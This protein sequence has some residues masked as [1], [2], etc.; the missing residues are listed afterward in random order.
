MLG[1]I[2]RE[3]TQRGSRKKYVAYDFGNVAEALGLVLVSG[4]P[5]TNL[6]LDMAGRYQDVASGSRSARMKSQRLDLEATGTSGGRAV[7]LVWKDDASSKRGLLG[8][9]IT[10]RQDARLS[11]SGVSGWPP[12]EV[13]LRKPPMA[14]IVVQPVLEGAEQELSNPDLASRFRLTSSSPL[15]AGAEEPLAVLASHWL[16]LVWDGERLD[17]LLN[18]YFPFDA[19]AARQR[20]GAMLELVALIEAGR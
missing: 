17:D 10:Y 14:G 3:A 7:E 16:H 9:T 6:L 15:P 4:D 19:D 1:K 8:T 13:V 18:P 5:A 12:F 11:V 2:L 20:L